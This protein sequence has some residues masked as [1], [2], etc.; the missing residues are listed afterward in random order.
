MQFGK[1]FLAFIRKRKAHKWP[2]YLRRRC[3]WGDCG[4]EA[5]PD[6]EETSWKVVAIKTVWCWH[7]NSSRAWTQTYLYLQTWC[8]T[9]CGCN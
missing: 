8:V 3:S 5:A 9:R 6:S 4:G 2:R 7:R 1:L